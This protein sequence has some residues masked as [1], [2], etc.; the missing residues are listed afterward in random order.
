MPSNILFPTTQ[1]QKVANVW[2]SDHALADEGSFFTAC[3]PTPLTGIAC[4]A[5][6]V[7]DAQTASATHGPYSPI[8]YMANKGTAGDP[9][10][11]SIYL[12]YIR[13]LANASA[14]F[15]SATD[16]RFAIRADNVPRYTSGGTLITP[17]NINT[18]STNTSAAQIYFGANVCANLPSSNSRLLAHGAITSSIPVAKEQWTFTFGDTVMPNS[19]LTATGAKNMNVACPPIII[20]PGWNIYLAMFGTAN[21]GT[22]NFEF[23][24]GYVERLSGL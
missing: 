23:E 4:T 16:W 19:I 2:N 18:G 10:A 8:L 24:I 7:D 14:T 13:I 15:T 9:N 21:A 12:K 20:A 5:S 1:A 17:V 6:V 3:N 11:K 22:P